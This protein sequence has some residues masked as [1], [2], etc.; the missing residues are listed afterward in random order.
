V[1]AIR[2]VEIATTESGTG[3]A[4]FWGHGF[5]SSM[6]SEVA[7][8]NWERLAAASRVIRWDARGHGESGGTDDSSTYRWDNL[9][10]DELALADMLG[11]DRFVAS[12]V[13]M[14]A[15]TALHAA[16]LA[17][18]R[19]VGLVLVLP[20]TAYETRPAQSAEYARGATMIEEHGVEAYVEYVN[21]KP[22][23][24]LLR[25]FA[26]AYRF[27]P[28]ISAELFPTVLRGA[29]AS[30]LPA[31]DDVR[32]ISVPVLLLAWTGDDGHPISTAE[33]LLE[34]LPGAK[35][36]VAERLRDVVG[37]TDVVASFLEG[38]HA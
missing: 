27:A 38:V 16:V 12:G 15:A 28:A 22:V 4:F 23:P 17:P 19:I 1:A 29:A 8:L 32:A 10:A 36:V 21:S 9:A 30:D 7:M 11:I 24:E 2:G 26:D 34:L 25:N 13:S 18:E 37:W 33:R 14:G 3:P 31:P 35:L 5:T 20:P 6:G